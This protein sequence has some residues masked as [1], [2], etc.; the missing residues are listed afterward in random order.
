MRESAV[1]RPAHTDKSRSQQNNN[2]APVESLK[3]EGLSEC[4][5]GCKAFALSEIDVSSGRLVEYYECAGCGNPAEI[6]RGGSR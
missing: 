1:G 6:Y 4:Y 3:F 2:S 5:C